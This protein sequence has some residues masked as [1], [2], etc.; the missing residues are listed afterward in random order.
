MLQAGEQ[1]AFERVLIAR[2]GSNQLASE[3]STLGQVLRLVQPLGDAVDA[4]TFFGEPA[5][6]S[7]CPAPVYLR[8]P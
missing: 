5:E 4:L 3:V 8:I 7:R 2:N 6:V 1:S